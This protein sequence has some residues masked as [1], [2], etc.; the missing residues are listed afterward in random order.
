MTVSN[1]EST[2]KIPILEFEVVT[3]CFLGKPSATKY[4]TVKKKGFEECILWI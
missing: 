3:F 4:K 2:L 1:L